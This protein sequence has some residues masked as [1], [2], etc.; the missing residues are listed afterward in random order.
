MEWLLQPR[1][2]PLTPTRRLFYILGGVVALGDGGHRK[3][4]A[5]M[6]TALGCVCTHTYRVWGRWVT[7]SRCK[8]AGKHS[9][10]SLVPLKTQ[11]SAFIWS[12]VCWGAKNNSEAKVPSR[13]TISNKLCLRDEANARRL[14]ISPSRTFLFF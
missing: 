14:L 1:Q 6:I 11:I 9:N 12:Q 3:Q 8:T 13:L 7:H 10:R 5:P 4:L 2:T